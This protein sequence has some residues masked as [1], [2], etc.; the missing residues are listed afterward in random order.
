MPSR[1][2]KLL[3]P[4]FPPLQR[5]SLNVKRH[6][7]IQNVIVINLSDP[8]QIP[9]LRRP[10]PRLVHGSPPNKKEPPRRSVAPRSPTHS[11]FRTYRISHPKTAAVATTQA[12]FTRNRSSAIKLMPNTTSVVRSTIDAFPNCIATTAINASDP[13]TT[14][15]SAAAATADLRSRGISGPLAATSTNPGKKIPTVATAAP[16]QPATTYPINVPVVN[17][18]PGVNCPTATA[19]I[20]CFSVSQCRRSTNSARRNASKTYPLPNTTD[21]TFRNDKNSRTS[22]DGKAPP[23]AV[24]AIAQATTFGSPT[25]SESPNPTPTSRFFI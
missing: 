14:P 16:V 22:L 8:R 1:Q 21:P 15:S 23:T 3:E 7:S 5:V 13:A 11:T 24:T 9:T 10:N 20:N 4:G 6:R 19:S 18:G 25:N 12:E 2:A 17:T